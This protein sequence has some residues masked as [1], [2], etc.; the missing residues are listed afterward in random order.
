MATLI[1]KNEL[2][3]QTS[4]RSLLRRV[5][6]F[7]L[8]L[9]HSGVAAQT[10]PAQTG[11]AG[12]IVISGAVPDEASKA[13]LLSRMQEVY[14]VGRIDDRISVGGVVAPPNWSSHVAKM[15]T[16]QLKAISKGQL[17]IEG[18]AVS[19]RGEVSNEAVRQEIASTLA[20]ALNP[21][22]VIRNGLRVAASSQTVLDNTLGNRIVEFEA[23]SA[24]LTE[25]GKHLL[26]EMTQ[27]LKKL[28]GTKVEV[29]G[30]TDNSGIPARNLALSRARADS[31]KTYL[32]AN[33]IPSE[34]IGTS[35]MGADQPVM[36]NATDDGR[37]RNRRIEFRLS[38]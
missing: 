17:A 32:I 4:Q 16:Q 2:L 1:M 11:A 38:Q 28:D 24:L 36:S 37:K 33:G 9:L 30:H 27:V 31:V 3:H 5:L 7:V 25:P 35:G 13:A 14:G 34:L 19:L 8:I 6:P 12:R 22:Y 29:I 20:G 21:T 15:V 23:G 10:T 18:T 26:D